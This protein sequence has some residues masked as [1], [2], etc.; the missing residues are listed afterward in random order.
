MT[1]P[2]FLADPALQLLLFGGKGGVGKTTCATATALRLGRC[3]PGTPLLLVSTDP[4]HSLL[5]CLAGTN[6]PPNLTVLELDAQGC[7]AR[8]KAKHQQKLHEIASRGTFLDE[9][10][11]TQLMGLS[12]PGMDELIAFLE[13]DSLVRSQKYGC[14]VVDTAPT[15]H[16]LRLL[17][18]PELMRTWLGALDALLAKH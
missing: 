15:G 8:F 2:S 17:A 10:D 5:D 1:L 9:D 16:T 7:L 4:A 11:I 6:I 13:I 18:M 14:I 3:R 12:L